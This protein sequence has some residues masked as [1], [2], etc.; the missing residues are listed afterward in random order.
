MPIE[1]AREVRPMSYMEF[2]NEALSH[3]KQSLS[4]IRAGLEPKIDAAI[5]QEKLDAIPNSTIDEPVPQTLE[6]VTQKL[7]YDLHQEISA[8]RKQVGRLEKII[9]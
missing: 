8:L 9:G 1:N 4:E 7:V 6:Q 3:M 2:V 5:G